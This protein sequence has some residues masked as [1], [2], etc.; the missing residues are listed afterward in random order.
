[1]S[2]SVI[3]A[4]LTCRT[5]QY[6]RYLCEGLLNAG[7]SVELWAS[8]CYADTL[9]DTSV[10]VQTG[11]TDYRLPPDFAGSVLAKG[12]KAAQYALNSQ[13]LARRIRHDRF[14]VV[15]FQWLPLLDVTSLELSW[16]RRIQQRGIPVV[17]TVHD[18]LPFDGDYSEDREQRFGEVYRQADALICHTAKSK[19]RLMQ[20]FSVP[21]TRVWHIPHG[22]LNPLKSLKKPEV[23]IDHVVDVDNDVPMVLFFGVIRP[24]KGIHFLLK[25]WSEV[26]SRVPDAQLA[27]VGSADSKTERAIRQ[28]IESLGMND[29]VA[30]T[31]RY[32]TEQE[33]ST[34]IHVA[35][36][37]VYPYQ[38]I[39]Q[40][41]AL[42]TGMA[43]AKAIV[44]TNVGGLGETLED[45]HTGCLVSY[46][47]HAELAASITGLLQD[48]ERRERLGRNA[49]HYLSRALSW[50]EIAEKT[51]QVYATLLAEVP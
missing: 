6:D 26:I 19:D 16:M 43:A 10:R 35:D 36:V 7:L 31:F 18:L 46:G 50:T 13:A 40:S 12:V 33:L 49:K 34:V 15:H 21:E 20:D 28:K 51:R 4:D 23:P 39:T 22:P 27:V 41:G 14:D 3:V 45:N 48:E 47:D 44:A 17:Y 1:M 5:P 29:R 2:P 42:F 9:E 25:A 11:C 8:G 30:C 38:R 24:N 37:V 32:V